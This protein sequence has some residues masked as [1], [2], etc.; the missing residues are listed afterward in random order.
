[1]HNNLSE[2]IRNC[3]RHAEDCARKAAEQIDPNLKQDFLELEESWLFKPRAS[4]L[5]WRRSE[6]AA[7]GR[8]ARFLKRQL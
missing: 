3:F 4:A 1:M 2:Q 8:Q 5:S 6:Q 7:C